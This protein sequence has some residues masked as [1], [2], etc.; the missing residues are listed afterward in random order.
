MKKYTTKV[1]ALD[2]QLNLI[3]VLEIVTDGYTNPLREAERLFNNRVDIFY[4]QYL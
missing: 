3:E 4:F 2:K 1:K